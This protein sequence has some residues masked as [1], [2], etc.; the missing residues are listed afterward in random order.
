MWRTVRPGKTPV[1][2]GVQTMTLTR[3]NTL[4]L[5]AASATVAATVGRPAL[6]AGTVV[7][8]SLW[9]K[10]DM[11]L[12]MLGKGEPM[13]M[14]MMG[15]D[16]AMKMAMLGIA[17]DVD[18][19]PAGEVTFEAVNDSK[20]MIHEMV[21]SPVADPSVPLPYIVDEDKVDE[22]AA[23]HVGEVA[24]LDPGMTGALTVTLEPGTYILYCNIPG[25]YILGMWTL[26]TVTA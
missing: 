25:H 24:E 7:K 4:A 11:S 13:G 8:V 16:M 15:A 26:L 1:N 18:T 5:F 20:S 10:G 6:A 19:V 17:L 23:G 14:G 22:D 12:D 9:D 21:V 3:R 2:A